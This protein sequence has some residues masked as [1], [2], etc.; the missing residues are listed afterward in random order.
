MRRCAP[1]RGSVLILVVWAVLLLSILAVGL[2]ARG[3]FALG[4]YDRLGE[5]L[6]TYWTAIGGVQ[7][8]FVAMTEDA[9]PRYDG[10]SE[11]WMRMGGWLRTTN[12]EI[13]V[14]VG[15]GLQDEDG[16]VNLNTAPVDVLRNLALAAGLKENEALEVADSIAD[17]RDADD[18]E[19]EHGAEGMTYRG[20]PDGY[21]CKN[22]PF[23]SMEELL[24]VK[25]VTPDLWLRLAPQVTVY[26]SG[27][28]NVNTASTETLLALGLSSKAVNSITAYRLGEDGQEGTL[29]D[30][31]FSSVDAILLEL[32]STLPVEDQNRLTKLETDGFLGVGSQA[33]HLDITAR[34]YSAKKGETHISCVV[35]RSGRILAWREM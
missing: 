28:L 33:F 5:D 29:D 14:E 15:K 9:T 17:W 2:A 34:S 26:G 23:E 13:L 3:V 30:R 1:A 11:E 24:F 22:G 8:A 27:R 18:D 35:D 10:S 31:V 16:K 32:G 20:L 4:M 21:D 19:R 7:A 12:P 25:G 6:Q